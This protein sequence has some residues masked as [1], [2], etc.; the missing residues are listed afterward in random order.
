[1]LTNF[2][3]AQTEDAPTTSTR[4]AAYRSIKEALLARR[5]RPGHMVSQREITEVTGSTLPAVREALKWLEAENVV[6]LIPKRGVTVREVT[7][8]EVADAYDLRIL[9]EMQAIGPF[10]RS[11]ASSE[12]SEFRKETEAL[13]SEGTQKPSEILEHFTRRVALDSSLHQRI[14]SAL[15]NELISDVH[16]SI[17]TVMLLARLSLPPQ[18]HADG[19]A[20]H[21]HLDLIRCIE[22]RDEAAAA[23]ALLSHLQEAR[24]RA[25]NSVAP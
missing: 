10:T 9:I 16:R 17:D 5:I 3:E 1:M 25:V 4:G 13:I 18:F 12:V 22:A 2:K 23:Q 6:R 19:P 24:T 8:K 7:R 20:F 11:V 15:D 21:E 14:V